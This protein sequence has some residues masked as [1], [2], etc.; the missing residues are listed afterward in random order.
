MAINNDSSNLPILI[1]MNF[2]YHGVPKG[3]LFLWLEAVIDAAETFCK[4]GL[5]RLKVWA[6]LIGGR[7]G[8]L[9]KLGGLQLIVSA[10]LIHVDH[11]IHIQFFQPGQLSA[12]G[13][14]VDSG[15]LL[16]FGLFDVPFKALLFQLVAKE[17]EQPCFHCRLRNL[18]VM[19]AGLS[20]GICP[21]L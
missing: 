20:L 14:P 7:C 6:F 3:A 1:H 8:P 5:H 16:A 4:N 18:L 15:G 13:G 11:F 21:A 9:G 19:V 10:V 2:L 17:G 12:D